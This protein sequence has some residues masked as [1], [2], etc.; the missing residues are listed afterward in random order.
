MTGGTVLIAIAVIAATLSIIMGLAWVVQQRTGNSGWVD[1]TWSFGVGLVGFVVAL[2]PVS[3]ADGPVRQCLVAGFAAIWALR[4]GLHI[5]TRSAH[6]G[7]D[8]R[9]AELIKGWGDDAPRQMFRFLQIQALA[10]V[11][12]ALAIFLAAHRPGAAFSLS[13]IVAAIVMVVAVGGEALADRQLRRFGA[14]PANKRGI[15]DTGLWH[16][17]RHPNYFF[18]ALGWLAYP[19]V[20]IDLSGDYDGGLLALA[21]PVWMYY[22]LVYASGIPPLEDHMLRTRG[23]AFRAYQRRT[24]AFFPWPPRR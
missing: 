19:I 13:D 14:N 18:E 2:V 9:Y 4:L 8:P 22:L 1:T 12:L 23:D 24:S 21:A 10:G 16:W 3:D 17:S 11:P 5:A 6:H 15:I 20:A 7:D